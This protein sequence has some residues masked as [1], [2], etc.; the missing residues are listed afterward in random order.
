V[1]C[2]ILETVSSVAMVLV[3]LEFR[4]R[5]VSRKLDFDFFQIY[6]VTRRHK[7]LPTSR[8]IIEEQKMSS[9]ILPLSGMLAQCRKGIL[10]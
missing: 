7:P 1:R 6:S 3:K 9:M 8:N 5:K 4:F 2:I 10:L